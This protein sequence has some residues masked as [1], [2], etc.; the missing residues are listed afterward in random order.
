[1]PCVNRISIPA[2][3][4]INMKTIAIAYEIQDKKFSSGF[5]DMQQLI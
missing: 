4:R 3:I 2:S 1:M 5:I